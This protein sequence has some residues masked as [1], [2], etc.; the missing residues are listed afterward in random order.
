M[1]PNITTLQNLL[2]AVKR[3]A[4]HQA[5]IK[6]LKGENFNLF[7]ILGMETAE[8][9]THSAFL[10]ELLNP[11]GSHGM[12]DVFL[13]LFLDTVEHG[14]HL[15]IGKHISV[16][17]EHHIGWVDYEK[18]AGGRID[19]YIEDRSKYLEKRI[20]KSISIE[21]KIN[22]G[23]QYLQIARYVNHNKEHNRVYYLTLHGDD[24]ADY[25]SDGYA[26]KEHYHCISYKKDIKIW[27]ERCIVEASDSP[28]L[29]ESI[30]QYM[31][32]IQKLTGQ[33]EEY[34]M[35]K[36]INQLIIQN[37]REAQLIHQNFLGASGE[38]VREFLEEVKSLI[39]LEL[40]TAEGWQTTIDDNLGE[41]YRGL[42]IFRSDW[43]GIS[44]GLKGNSKIIGDQVF[45]GICAARSTWDRSEM[46]KLIA[47]FRG[48]ESGFRQ[49]HW[50][51]FYQLVDLF[52][53]E[54]GIE[55]MCEKKDW[56]IL[57]PGMA[58][59][60]INLA[61]QCKEPLTQIPRLA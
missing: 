18:K 8:N 61:K 51:P 55:R 19:I 41:S 25:S 7:S 22:A 53:G 1:T 38:R 11:K 10:G 2:T 23:D 12:G 56:E 21:N 59:L 4:D 48:I 40:P 42:N 35:E 49:D 43:N 36:E 34:K 37:Y 17:L 30:K 9:K 16:T 15:Q 6:R 47:S 33:L 3:V 60:V 54:E 31:I 44:L 52:N 28:I 5:E 24:A 32:L 39:E 29:R 58:S 26:S 13:E 14:G 45:Y 20:T 46:E 27:L 57:V 50:W